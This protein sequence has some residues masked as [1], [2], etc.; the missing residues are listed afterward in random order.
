MELP[1]SVGLVSLR[2]LAPRI[3]SLRNEHSLNLLGIEAL[4]AAKHLGA[5]VFLS[6]R[7]P[8]LEASLQRE[9]LVVQV[10]SP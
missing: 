5:D 3:G 2:D 6:A 1:Q 7:S 9:G 4:A 8:R 10:A